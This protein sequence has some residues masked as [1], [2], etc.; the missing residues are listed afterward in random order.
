MSAPPDAA[1][2]RTSPL[3]FY[4]QLAELL[5]HEIASGNWGPGTRLPS[6]PDLCERYGLSRTTV[7]Q[8]LGRLEQRGL[9][10][11]FKGQGS[12]VRRGEPG[13][14]LLQSSEGFFHDEVDRLGRTVTSAILR[15]EAE[16]LPAWA[17]RT[18][19][20]PERSRG[21]SLERLRSVDNLVALYVVNYLVGVAADAA[22]AIGNPNESLY[23]RLRERAGV[24]PHGGRRTLE[25]I[26]AEPAIAERLELEPGAPVAFIESVAWDADQRPFDCYRAWLRTDRTKVDIHATEPGAAATHPLA[27]PGSSKGPSQ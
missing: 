13:L 5:E 12:F 3:P 2:D 8:A 7:R 22:L 20:V 9:I 18:L 26:A 23:R 25:A 21:A 27:V 4:F 11:R 6:E 17:C 1:I 19:Q 15:A 14:W 10:E 24:I 16:V